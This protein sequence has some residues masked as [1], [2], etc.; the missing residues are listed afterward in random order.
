MGKPVKAVFHPFLRCCIDGNYWHHRF[1]DYWLSFLEFLKIITVIIVLIEVK[2]QLLGIIEIVNHVLPS[3][4]SIITFLSPNSSVQE[5]RLTRTRE[6]HS[7]TAQ[8]GLRRVLELPTQPEPRP[9]APRPGA[10]KNKA[11]ERE[12]PAIL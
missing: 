3:S 10:G 4:S 12:A 2:A 1:A 9:S 5:A 8:P 6:A 11:G 7:A